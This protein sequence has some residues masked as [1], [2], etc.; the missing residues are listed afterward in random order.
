MKLWYAAM[1]DNE[2]TDWGYG[3]EDNNTAIEMVR[4]FWNDRYLDAY[5][6]VIDLSGKE[7]MCIKE[8]RYEE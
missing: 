2:D 6:A 4:Q 1:M 3:S 8:I 7:P 5:I